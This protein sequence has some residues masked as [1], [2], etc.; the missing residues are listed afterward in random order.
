MA[1]RPDAHELIVGIKTDPI[2]GPVILFGHGGTAVEAVGD[3]A[4]ALPPLNMTLAREV[5]G[6]TRVEKLLLGYR[7]HRRG[8]WTP[9]VPPSSEFPR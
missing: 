3:S 7:D 8:I 4:V 6:R 1:E 5:I 9:S 2:F